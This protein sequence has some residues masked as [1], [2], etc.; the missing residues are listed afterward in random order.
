MAL[1]PC[2]DPKE[3]VEDASIVSAACS[4]DTASKQAN[5]IL[6]NTVGLHKAIQ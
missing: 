3:F 2:V 5:F 6:V 4:F 1:I